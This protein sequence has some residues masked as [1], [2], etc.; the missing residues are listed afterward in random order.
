MKTY[1]TQLN[2]RE[3][4]MVSLGILCSGLY[5]LYLVIY[6]P[7]VN[8]VKTQTEQ[9]IE[10]QSTLTWMRQ[11]QRQ[12]KTLAARKAL[13]NTQ[14]LTL[15]AKQLRHTSFQNYPYQ[16]QQTGSGDVQ[17]VFKQ[18][19]FNAFLMWL[20]SLHSQNKMS[21]KELR[22]ERGD[23]SGITSMQVIIAVQS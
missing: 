19:P 17:L 5:L 9:L 8:S 14:L 18:V 1:W 20:W 4:W 6:L 10:K 3:R 7:L 12:H 23:V 22:A 13:S 11:V 15:I 16:L 2:E 21:I